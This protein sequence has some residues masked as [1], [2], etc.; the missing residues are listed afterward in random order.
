MLE[1]VGAMQ[2]NILDEQWIEGLTLH[3]AFDVF[4]LC[5]I[6]RVCAY[7]HFFVVEMARFLRNQAGHG[8]KVVLE[9][10]AGRVGDD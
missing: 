4:A 10:I 8:Q 6:L 1:P 7:G 9:K 3:I 5:R 2:V